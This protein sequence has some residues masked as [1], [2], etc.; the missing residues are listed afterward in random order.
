[1]KLPSAAATDA[2]TIRR[3]TRRGFHSSIVASRGT[4]SRGRQT[5]GIV[6][7]TTRSGNHPMEVAASLKGG[8]GGGYSPRGASM[9]LFEPGFVQRPAAP[10]E[11]LLV[12]AAQLGER[13]A[14]V[15]GLDEPTVPDVDRRM[16]DLRSLR[17]NAFRAEEEDVRGLELRERDP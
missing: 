15:G 13:D 10:R 9:P 7:A 5:K 14:V 8:N 2:P 16:E 6:V 1:M 4:L 3:V 11:L 17:V 12:P